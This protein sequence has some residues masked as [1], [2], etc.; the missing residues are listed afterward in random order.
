MTRGIPFDTQPLIEICRHNDVAMLGV[1][2]SVARGE[3]TQSS[4]TVWLTARDDL[5]QLKAEIT[6]ILEE[7]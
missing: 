3:A 2:G 7:I 1:F 6:R 5:P 4:D